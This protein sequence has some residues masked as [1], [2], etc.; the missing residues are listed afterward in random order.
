M[1]IISTSLD[2]QAHE[3]VWFLHI[4]VSYDYEHKDILSRKFVE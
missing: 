3:Y 1:E 4:Y 2:M